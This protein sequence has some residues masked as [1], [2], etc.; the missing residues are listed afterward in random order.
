M[1]RIAPALLLF[2]ACSTAAYGDTESSAAGST[3]TSAATAV[4]AATTVTDGGGASTGAPTTG[5]TGGGT[6]VAETSGGTGGAGE[7]YG[8]AGA[9]PPGNQTF[10]LELPGRSLLVEVWYPAEPAAHRGAIG[11]A[12]RR[13]IGRAFRRADP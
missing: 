10:T 4:T 9:N 12:A 2:T 6:T 8:Q 1:R 3:G 7:D 13:P 5:G 11:R